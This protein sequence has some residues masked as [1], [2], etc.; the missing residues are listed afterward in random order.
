MSAWAARSKEI[1]Q[2]TARTSKSYI[3]LYN[4]YIYTA[5]CIVMLPVCSHYKYI[6]FHVSTSK[7]DRLDV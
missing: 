5:R 1:F 7:L 6:I 2:S 4:Y 3:A